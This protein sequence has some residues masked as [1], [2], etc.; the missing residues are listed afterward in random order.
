MFIKPLQWQKAYSSM[1][2]TLFGIVTFVSAPQLEN[3]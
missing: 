2:V 3:A 1:F